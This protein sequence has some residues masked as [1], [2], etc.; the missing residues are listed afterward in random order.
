MRGEQKECPDWTVSTSL[1]SARDLYSTSKQYSQQVF[2]RRRTVISIL[3]RVEVVWRSDGEGCGGGFRGCG[4]E[5]GGEKFSC[6]IPHT[7]LRFENCMGCLWVMLVH[8]EVEN[9]LPGGRCHAY[10]PS[11]FPPPAPIFSTRITSVF[12]VIRTSK[13]GSFDLN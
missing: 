1:T 5:G 3:E 10:K 9:I 6:L 13:R 12:S 11:P 4:W 7:H 8:S 2:F